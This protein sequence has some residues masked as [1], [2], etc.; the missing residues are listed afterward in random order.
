[1]L[2]AYDRRGWIHSA[3]RTHDGQHPEAVIADM[4]ADPEVA[5]IHSRN[6]AWGC[7]MF[8]VT[9]AAVPDVPASSSTW[10][11]PSTDTVLA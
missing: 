8:T 2:R 11:P 1:M 6:I 7:Y 3:T 4:L 5:Q 10:R 9:R